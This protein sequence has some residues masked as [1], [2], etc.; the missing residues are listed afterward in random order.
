MTPSSSRIFADRTIDDLPIG[1]PAA[2]R[3][4]VRFN[5][6]AST[7]APEFGGHDA[8]DLDAGGPPMDGCQQSGHI[9]IGPYSVV[10]LSRET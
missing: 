1:F 9:S 2:G 8:F 3:W 7:Y 6:D 10:V 5:S 4:N